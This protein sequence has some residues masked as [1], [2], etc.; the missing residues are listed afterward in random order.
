MSTSTAEMETEAA[1]AG[2]HSNLT[3]GASYEQLGRRHPEVA[4]LGSS[5]SAGHPPEHDNDRN[6]MVYFTLLTAGI[7]FV[8][9]YNRW[10][11]GWMGVGV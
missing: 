5:T 1:S 7:G 9:P 3:S 10:V 6:N 2:D 8:L 11:G 4:S